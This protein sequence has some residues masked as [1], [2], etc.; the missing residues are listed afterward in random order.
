MKLTELFHQNRLSLS[1]E[2]FPPKT[3]DLYDGVKKATEEIAKISPAFMS[4]TY[5]AGGGTSKYTLDIAKNLK[6]SCG[7]ESLAHLTCVSS[8]RETVRE[9]IENFKAA[10]I[11]NVMALRGDIPKDM[12]NED[13]A[14]WHYRHAIDLVRELKAS[15]ADFCIG[16]A[17]Y[18]EA[19]PESKNQ[20]EDIRY[21]KEKSDAGCDFLTTQMFFDNGL[22]Y[23]F[24]DK[25][26]QAGINVPVLAGIMPITNAKQITRV[27][28]LSGSFMPQSFKKMIYKFGDD[29]LAMKKA[30]IEY[31]T[32]QI[33][34][35]FVNGIANV[36][37][38]SMNNADVAKTIYQNLSDCIG[39]HV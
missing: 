31:A 13:R 23:R 8:T 5:G 22:L 28:K 19:H 12:E 20:N 29:P 30:G 10:G 38:Y 34:D 37:V 9:R 17:C 1:F 3:D 36:H 6:E 25:I 27:V 21:L 33:R 32:D 11:E 35:L 39:K 26:R 7:V 2:V 24:M 15:G 14:Q 16:G 18:P 4:V